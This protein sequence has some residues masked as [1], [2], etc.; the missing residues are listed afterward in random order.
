M[1]FLPLV[2]VLGIALIPRLSSRAVKFLA[3]A[4]T[5]AVLAAGS[6]DS[7]AATMINR[8]RERSARTIRVK[9]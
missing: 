7:N 5:L 8:A 2:G 4:F 3:L 9:P 6:Q 1:I